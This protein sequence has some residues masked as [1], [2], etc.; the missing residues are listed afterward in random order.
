MR[1]LTTTN[2][3]KL[4]PLLTEGKSM[5]AKAAIL[6]S[7]IETA[8][9]HLLEQDRTHSQPPLDPRSPWPEHCSAFFRETMRQLA[10][11]GLYVSPSFTDENANA[12]EL[13]RRIRLPS[14]Q[15]EEVE[16]H[17]DKQKLAND[18]VL[19][20][21]SEVNPAGSGHLGFVY[22]VARS[23]NPP[24]IRDGNIHRDK[25][26]G[27]I[28]APSSYGAVPAGLAFHLARTKWFKYRR[29]IKS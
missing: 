19:V 8:T 1:L 28:T 27:A 2:G 22:P 6:V 5:D 25:T 21:G 13:G 12:N 15:W 23:A 20:V 26:T 3:G 18:G 11:R 24:F 17:E 10:K 16:K 14:H 4:S 7:A 29:P 9:R